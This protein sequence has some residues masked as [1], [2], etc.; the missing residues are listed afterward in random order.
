MFRLRCKIFSLKIRR[1]KLLDKFH[2]WSLHYRR[3]DSSTTMAE[4]VVEET[5]T[6][7]NSMCCCWSLP[8]EALYTLSVLCSPPNLALSV[9]SS[10]VLQILLSSSLLIFTSS[11][12]TPVCHFLPISSSFM[13]IRFLPDS[14][15]SLKEG[16]CFSISQIIC[17][18]KLQG[19]SD[20]SQPSGKR[21]AR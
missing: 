14:L 21:T 8:G 7:V 18:H 15:S 17:L 13:W 5:R 16:Q 19:E 12:S 10:P 4:V 11:T 20:T 1:C 3:R 2:V 9:P 6:V